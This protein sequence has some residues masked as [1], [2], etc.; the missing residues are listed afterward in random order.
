LITWSITGGTLPAGLELDASTG[1]ISGTPTTA[2][3]FTFVVEVADTTGNRG[4]KT[5]TV[6][7]V[8]GGVPLVILPDS[9]P[10]GVVGQLYGAQL[11][12]SSA[13]SGSVLP[14]DHILNTPILKAPVV[15]NS[16]AITASIGAG[17]TVRLDFSIPVNR[18]VFPMTPISF[19]D[20]SDSDPGPYPIPGNAQIEGNSDQRLIVVATD[21]NKLYEVFNFRQGVSLGATNGASWDLNSYSLRPLGNT[22]A[23]VAGLPI[24][25]LLLRFEDFAKGAIKHALRCTVRVFRNF[26]SYADNRKTF[27]A[28]WPARHSTGQN[29]DPNM[30]AMGTR[31]RLKAS[32][33]DSQLSADTRI[34]TACMKQYGLMV[35]DSGTALFVQGDTDP[36]WT[37]SLIDKITTDCRNIHVSDFEVVDGVTP[38]LIDPNSGK[39]RQL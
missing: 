37:P 16:D 8:Q 2:G 6:P 4:T 38:F 28:D 19:D 33:D 24:Y 27:P 13:G 17:A 22:S 3:T 39:A 20:P 18:G 15:P 34:L 23:D 9:L 10:A 25:P 7:I 11:T 32:F 1:R 29:V 30:P 35:A 5:Y 21:T 14:S 12:V 36:G 26:G 31:L